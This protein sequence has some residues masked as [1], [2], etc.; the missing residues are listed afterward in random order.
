MKH[1]EKTRRKQVKGKGKI[2][3]KTGVK[4]VKWRFP[5]VDRVRSRLQSVPRKRQADMDDME[6]KRGPASKR[7][8]PSKAKQGCVMIHANA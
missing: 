6:M 8:K 3:E 7:D 2:G 1:E 5:K 4:K